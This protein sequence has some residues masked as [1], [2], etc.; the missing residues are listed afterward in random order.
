MKPFALFVTLST[1]ATLAICTINNH[2]KKQ[3]EKEFWNQPTFSFNLTSCRDDRNGEDCKIFFYKGPGSILV[4]PSMERVY[5]EGYLGIG[6]KRPIKLLVEH[7]YKGKRIGN[8]PAGY[9]LASC[10]CDQE[11]CL[12]K[13]PD[14]PIYLEYNTLWDNYS[15]SKIKSAE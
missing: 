13:S 9:K 8:I 15:F 11:E 3:H 4:F 1:I 2:V 6:R 10:F 14:G 5:L 12:I 7:G